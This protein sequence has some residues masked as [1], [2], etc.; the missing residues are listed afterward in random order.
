MKYKI[1]EPIELTAHFDQQGNITPL[2]FT[3]KGGAYRVEST[4]RH[5]QDETGLHLLAMVSSGKI[6]ELIYKSIERRWYIG[7]TEHDRPVV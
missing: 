6:I 7:R 5:W 3:W 1:M 2:H 4:G